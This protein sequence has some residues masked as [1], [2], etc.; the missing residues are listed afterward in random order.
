MASSIECITFDCAEPQRVAAFWA[1]A[2]GYE[3]GGENGGWIW[4]RDPRGVGPL[5]GFDRVPEP[6]VVKNR[7]HLDLK[8]SDTM[9][10]EVERLRGLGAREVRLVTN[11][12]DEMHTVM[13]DPEGNEFCVVRP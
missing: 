12:P 8:P 9:E 3:K 13:Q 5:L 4:L 6:K 7:M 2:L 10:A 1:A 11:D